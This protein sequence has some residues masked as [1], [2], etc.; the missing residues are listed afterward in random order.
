[1]LRLPTPITHA[2]Y[3]LLIASGCS[4]SGSTN[5]AAP[6]EGA[7]GGSTSVGGAGA[8]GAVTAAGRGGSAAGGPAGAGVGGSSVGG[9]GGALGTGGQGTGGTQPATG[10]AA[11]VAATGG[12]GGTG[13][14]A[15][16]GG[17]AAQGGAAGAGKGGSGASAGSTSGGAAGSVG[18]AGTGTSGAAGQSSG[19]PLAFPGAQGFGKK[20]TGGRNGHVY[21]VTTLADSGAGSF[22]DA[23]SASDR[24]VVFDVG[25]YID[26]VTAVSVKSNITIAG[27][28]APGGGIGFR[29]G[30]ISFANSSNIICRFVRVRPGSETESTDD[31]ALSL[32]RAQNVMIDH[33]SFEFG[34]W[35]DIDGVSDD[36]QNH[37]VT[38]ITIQDSLI[39]DPTG[40]QFGAHT[41]SV[42]SQWAWYRNVFANSHN[43][44]PLAK[45][46]TVFV[47]NVL[48]NDSAGYTT[49]TSTSFQHDIVNNYFVFGPASTGTDNTWF[50]IDQNQSIYYAGN[51]KDSNLNG[52]LDGAATTPYWYQGTGTV[53]ARAWSSETTATP[54]LDTAS[55]ARVAI[56]LAGTLPRDP[57]DALII[58]QVLTLGKGTTGY[59]AGSVGPD[60]TLYTSQ[61]QTGLPNGGYGQIAGGTAPTDGDKDG[62]PDDWEQA[63]GSDPSADDA[64]T[65]ASDGYTLLEHYANW[66]A[67]PHARAA[68]G[69][70][71]DVD[72]TAYAAGFSGVAP[73]FTASGAVNGSV[74]LQADG[75]TARFQPATGFRGLGSFAFGVK[76]SDG[77][78]FTS[79]VVVLAVP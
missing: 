66:L 11:G 46:N 5:G 69:S 75:H 41:E 79:E 68:G 1:M 74:T 16:G 49:H 65:K 67:A 43:R 10:G 17:S 23:V 51:L 34:P 61:S 56:S 77:T 12:A 26:L 47:N 27:Q 20:A 22:R 21:H 6:N 19:P 31:D 39:A 40:Q 33:S 72:L 2:L 25:G 73:T 44:N 71:V 64:M 42:S 53:L 59:G 37:P 62:M 70:S 63:N 60:G 57:V 15:G 76:G 38:D 30:E 28:T 48:Y 14:I 29:G 50:Q 35:N 7:P 78:A 54:P 4:S 52:T 18:S 36:W 55:G 32:Y 8:S 45:V 13:A 9:A 58:S 3:L 24:F